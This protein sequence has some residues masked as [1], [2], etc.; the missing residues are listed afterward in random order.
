MDPFWLQ[1]RFARGSS[2]YTPS[3]LCRYLSEKPLFVD[4]CHISRIS[5][6]EVVG[7]ACLRSLWSLPETCLNAPPRG[8]RF[9]G[10]IQA[11]NNKAGP[12]S[13]GLRRRAGGHAY[14]ARCLRRVSR[15]SHVSIFVNSRLH[16]YQRNVELGCVEPA[17]A[18]IK[19]KVVT[20]DG[21]R[22]RAVGACCSTRPLPAVGSSW[23]CLTHASRGSGTKCLL[24]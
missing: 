11:S 15:R 13:D 19:N 20:S 1:M 21:L 24:G 9:I 17:P 10:P 6:R 16:N 7:A 4:F 23:C 22:R 18:N 14:G 2:H 8:R 3:A 5:Q 12:T